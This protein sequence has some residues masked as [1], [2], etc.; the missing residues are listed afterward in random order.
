LTGREIIK[1][2]HEPA[3]FPKVENALMNA[4]A[5]A[6]FDGGWEVELLIQVRNIINPARDCAIR[7]LDNISVRE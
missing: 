6:R 3:I 2:T 7:N 4:R 1:N 5:T